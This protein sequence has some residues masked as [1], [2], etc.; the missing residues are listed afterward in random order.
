MTDG[1]QSVN[2]GPGGAIAQHPERLKWRRTARGL[3][4]NEAAR[5]A[6]VS[7]AHLSMLERGIHG[8]SP[9]VLRRLAK[10]YKCKIADLMPDDPGKRAA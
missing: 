1:T 8:A 10:L 2:P 4:L 6:E 9:A 3:G 7:K 5:R